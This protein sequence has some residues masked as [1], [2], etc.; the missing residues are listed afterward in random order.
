MTVEPGEQTVPEGEAADFTVTYRPGSE[1]NP[2]PTST[3]ESGA[4]APVTIRWQSAPGPDGPWTDLDESGT[5]LHTTAAPG[6][7]GTLIR[8]EVSSNG[9]SSSS[10]PAVLHVTPAPAPVPTIA[11]ASPPASCAS[12]ESATGSAD[13][14]SQPGRAGGSAADRPAGEACPAPPG[15]AT[16]APAPAAPYYGTVADPV[17]ELGRQQTAVGHNFV[18]GSLVKVTLDGVDLGTSQAAPDGTVTTRFDTSSLLAGSHTVVWTPM[19]P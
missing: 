16:P 7:D 9:E 12:T 14:G 19:T 1:T 11:T 6:M 18:P 4:G 3:P 2:G 13:A 17:I 10:T 15:T 8:A 5:D